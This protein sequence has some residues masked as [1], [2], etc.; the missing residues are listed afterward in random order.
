MDVIDIRHQ[1]PNYQIY[2]DWR[3]PDPIEGI[4]I[5]HGGPNTVNNSGVPTISWYDMANVHVGEEGRAHVSY[6]YGIDWRGEVFYMLDEQIGGYH[7]ALSAPAPSDQVAWRRWQNDW[8]NGQYF[9][10]RTVS[11]VLL[12][13]FDR[14]RRHNGRVL[15]DNETTRPSAAQWQALVEL[16]RDISERHRVPLARIEGHR[17]ALARAGFGRTTCPGLQLNMGKLR[18]AVRSGSIRPPA[19]PPPV[20]PP[21]LE[22]D[23]SG[24]SGEQAPPPVSPPNLGGH[25]GGLEL[26]SSQS[27]DNQSLVRLS[28]GPVVVSGAAPA[29]TFAKN[30]PLIGLHGRND[31]VFTNTDWQII[32]QARVESL[33]MMSY[34]RDEVYAQ[35]RQID[36]NMEFIVR[37]YSRRSGRGN[38]PSPQ[39]FADMFRDTMDR[40]HQSFGVLKFE[41]HNEPNHPSGLEGWGSSHA[42]ALAFQAW[43]KQTFSILRQRHPW[44]LLGYPGLSIPNNDLEWL[45]WNREAIEMSD[46]LGMH[47]YWQTPPHLPNNFTSDFWGFRFKAYHQKFPH[48]LI[49]ITEFANSNGQSPPLGLSRYEQRRQYDWWLRQI[50]QYPYIGSAH[51][52]IATSPDPKWVR[53]GF[54][55]G[56]G[57]RVFEVAPAVGAINRPARRPDWYYASQAKMPAQLPTDVELTFPVSVGNGGRLPW[58]NEGDSRTSVKIQWVD[59]NQALVGKARW[60]RLPHDVAPGDHAE[61]QVKIQTPAQEGSYSLQLRLYHSGQKKWFSQLDSSTGPDYFPTTIAETTR[62]VPEVTPPEVPEVTLP[63]LAASYSLVAVPENGITKTNRLIE[64]EVRNEGSRRWETNG[65]QLG[66]IRLGY[67]WLNEQSKWSEGRDRGQLPHPVSSGESAR[68]IMPLRFPSLPGRYTLYIRLLSE[69][70]RWFPESIERPV[71]VNAPSALYAVQYSAPS[72]AQ[73]MVGTRREFAVQL[74]NTGQRVWQARGNAPIT[75]VHYWLDEQG[76]SVQPTWRVMLPRD[77]PPAD[78]VTVTIP[79]LAPGTPGQYQLQVDMAEEG[80]V[81]FSQQGNAPLW[82]H[83]TVQPA[84]QAPPWGAE[85]LLLDLPQ[86]LRLGQS[87]RINV[88]VRNVGQNIWSRHNVRIAYRWDNGSPNRV[89]LPVDVLPGGE[90]ALGLPITPSQLGTHPIIVDLWHESLGWLNV[91]PSVERITVVSADTPIRAL[92]APSLTPLAANLETQ[93]PT[94]QDRPQEQAPPPVE[95]LV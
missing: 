35:A 66:S 12:G 48:K 6:H 95:S 56:D 17:E 32:R 73:I 25:R 33:K 87:G 64:V 76:R 30:R 46:W 8:F 47:T 54:T 71:Q 23:K 77:V 52:F 21:N 38:I 72:L 57:E 18:D 70:E 79:L 41:I 11:I 39:E 86:Q 24:S 65:E 19:P 67:H 62:N 51:G 20:S 22:G 42:D 59:G 81:F 28:S 88:R 16:V 43:Y 14:N 27:V 93:D 5:H 68:I 78:S 89:A 34:I 80:Q 4:L 44:A 13:W 60:S 45:D 31:Y 36:P 49:E 75:V 58:I 91:S 3:R 61:F 26:S 85:W 10:R 84:L 37:L 74:R 9:N 94:R 83:V 40:L 55:W 1:M 92:S 50:L 63:E 69:F 29:L 7:A 53:E 90:M 2:R 15:P 82:R